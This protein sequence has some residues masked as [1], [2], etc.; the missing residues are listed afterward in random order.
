M[1]AA[2]TTGIRAWAQVWTSDVTTDARIPIQRIARRSVGVSTSGRASAA[3]KASGRSRKGVIRS[4]PR[5]TP[6]KAKTICPAE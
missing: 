2:W 6:R 4:R 3:K 5:R 1:T